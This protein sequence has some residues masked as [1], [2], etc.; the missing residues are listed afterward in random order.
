M[1][2][3]EAVSAAADIVPSRRGFMRR[4]V[5]TLLSPLRNR[6]R[7]LPPQDDYLKRDIGLHERENPRE[8]WEYWWHHS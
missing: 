3:D 1:P 4:A 2:E 5:S 6:R 7:F 8:Y